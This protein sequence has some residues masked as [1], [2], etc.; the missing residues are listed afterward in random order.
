LLHV[1][2]GFADNHDNPYPSPWLTLIS[3]LATEVL[4]WIGIAT[5]LEKLTVSVFLSILTISQLAFLIIFLTKISTH[6]TIVAT[7]Q[8]LVINSSGFTCKSVVGLFV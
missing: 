8:L 6:H 1:V 5:G 7:Y 4:I 3:T 2:L